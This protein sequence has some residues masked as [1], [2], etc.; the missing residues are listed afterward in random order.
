MLG[1]E[2]RVDG[3]QE[4]TQKLINFLKIPVVTEWNS[5]DL[6][7]HENEFYSGRPGTIGD[8]GGN[9][10]VQNCDLLPQWGVTINQTNK[11]RMGQFYKRCI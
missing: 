7:D 10:V 11:L 8:R 5:H 3:A 4:I 1:D 2:V 6:I 9:Y